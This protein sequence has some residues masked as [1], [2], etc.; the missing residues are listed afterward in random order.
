[1]SELLTAACISPG[2][3]SGMAGTRISTKTSMYVDIQH[4]FA[5]GVPHDA[6]FI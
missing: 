2:D 5:Q 4:N 3:R 6:P 1:V